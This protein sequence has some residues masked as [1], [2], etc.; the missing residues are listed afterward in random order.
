MPLDDALETC[1]QYVDCWWQPVERQMT[2]RYSLLL[3]CL[4]LGKHW[5][6]LYYL[7]GLKIED[8]YSVK[9]QAYKTIGLLQPVA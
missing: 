6:N 9:E 5:Q 7:Y 8:I 2:Y 1:M 3:L 4:H